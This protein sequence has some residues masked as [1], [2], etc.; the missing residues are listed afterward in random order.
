LQ[1]D[2]HDNVGFA[3]FGFEGFFVDFE[4]TGKFF[5]HRGLDDNS[6]IAAFAFFGFELVHDVGSE[7]HHIPDIDVAAEKGVT[8]FF[9]ALFDGL[10]IDG[11]G[12]VEFLEG[13][14]YFFAELC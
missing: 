10:F 6:E 5:D 1:A 4:Q 9:E 11:G 14:L 12:A 2:E 7:F 3:S 8:D 13:C